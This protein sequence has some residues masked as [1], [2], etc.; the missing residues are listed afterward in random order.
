MCISDTNIFI[1]KIFPSLLHL[2]MYKKFH[3]IHREIIRNNARICILY[4]YTQLILKNVTY[5]IK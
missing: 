2:K 3:L 1:I 4:I 5:F